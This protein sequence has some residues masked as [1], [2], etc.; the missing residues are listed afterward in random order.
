MHECGVAMPCDRS[1]GVV[2][3]GRP[4]L[5]SPQGSPVRSHLKSALTQKVPEST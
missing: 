4:A 1:A 5:L 2:R 3:T